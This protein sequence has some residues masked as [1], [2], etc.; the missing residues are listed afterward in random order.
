MKNYVQPGNALTFTATAAVLAGEGVLQGNLFGVAATDADTGEDFEAAIVGVFEL[1]K[2]AVALSRGARAYWSSSN[3][4]VT[5]T[6][7]GNALIG[8]VTDDVVAG[9]STVNVRLNR[10]V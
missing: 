2:A 10:T 5:G 7:S 8:A 6:A 9:A 1:P 3:S 4:N